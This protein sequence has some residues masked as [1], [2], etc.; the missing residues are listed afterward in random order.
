MAQTVKLKDGTEVLIREMTPDDVDRSLA[1]FEALPKEDT[2]FLRRPIGGRDH[3]VR[4]IKTIEAGTAERLV[5]IVDDRIVADGALEHDPDGWR[6]HVGEIRLIVAHD[7]QGRGLGRLMAFELYKLANRAKVEEIIVKI[8]GPQKGVRK[9]FEKL[10]FHHEAELHD[11][12]KDMSGVRHDLILMRCKLQE[13]WQR[14]EA[15]ILA[16]DWRPQY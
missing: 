12:V 6:E 3:I 4:R 1:F 7:F 9:M 2:I 11:F 14:M 15:Q 5:A 13:L 8:M 10:G 16:S